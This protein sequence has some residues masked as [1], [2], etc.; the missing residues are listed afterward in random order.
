MRRAAGIILIIICMV[1][2]V[3]MIIALSGKAYSYSFW[4]II[5]FAVSNWIVYGGLLLTGGILCLKRRYWGLCLV[6]AL[7]VLS[8]VIINLVEHLLR[9]GLYMNWFTWIV[10]PGTLIA[11]IFISVRKKEWQEISDSVDG[12]V[13]SDD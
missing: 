2:L 10:L 8:F 7:L 9:G 11:A 1:M 4:S 13:C 3:D 5:W 6:S 12:K